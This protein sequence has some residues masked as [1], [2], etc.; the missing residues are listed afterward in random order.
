MDTIP[1]RVASYQAAERPRNDVRSEAK[2]PSGSLLHG[3]VLPL[4]VAL[5]PLL[6]PGCARVDSS[7][8]TEG[9]L[10]VLVVHGMLVA[11]TAEQ[12]I[13]VEYTRAIEEGIDRAVLTPASGARVSVESGGTVH[14]FMEDPAQPGIYRARFTPRAGER[15]RLRI[16]GPRGETATAETVIPGTPRITVPSAD[17]TVDVRTPPNIGEV[18]RF[19]WTSA[20]GA[21]YVLVLRLPTRDEP[22]EFLSLMNAYRTSVQ[23]DTTAEHPFGG[24]VSYPGGARV[25]IAAVDSNYARFVSRDPLETIPESRARSP[26]EGAYGLFGSVAFSNTRLISVRTEEP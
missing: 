22:T 23:T 15:Y 4:A 2:L 19:H 20:P 17:T 21:G 25:N 7:Y 26:L 24:L 10:R 12:E 8:P 3:V 14:P 6:V 16:E 18:V 5:L 11:D 1:I 9:D 13:L